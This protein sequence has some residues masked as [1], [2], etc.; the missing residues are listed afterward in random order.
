MFPVLQVF[1]PPSIWVLIN[2]LD[3]PS[4]MMISF[5][6]NRASAKNYSDRFH[7]YKV[8]SKLDIIVHILTVNL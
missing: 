5:V 7:D 6:T 3:I 8:K 4:E 2:R 1:A